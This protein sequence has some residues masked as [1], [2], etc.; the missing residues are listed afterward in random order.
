MFLDDQNLE[1]FWKI[2][3][4]NVFGRSEFGMFI[5][6]LPVVLSPFILSD[7]RL[8]AEDNTNENGNA[9]KK[10]VNYSR[11]SQQLVCCLF[12]LHILQK[13]SLTVL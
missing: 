10:K 11:L 8:L 3:I 7:S 5:F 2:R 6:C 9:P 13:L 4:W 12:Y 1:C